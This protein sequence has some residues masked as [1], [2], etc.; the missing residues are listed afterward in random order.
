M[1]LDFHDIK[2]NINEKV[3]NKLD[4][5]YLNDIIEN[6]TTENI[7]IWTRDQLKDLKELK[8][9]KLFETENSFAELVL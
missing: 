8:R 7:L 6:P 3:I 9:L 4:H 1:I 2:K 5:K